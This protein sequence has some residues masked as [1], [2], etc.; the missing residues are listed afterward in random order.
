VVGHYAA[1][2]RS[3]A[4]TILTADDAK[5]PEDRHTRCRP[6]PVVGSSEKSLP[7][8]AS[9]DPTPTAAGQTPSVL[10][11]RSRRTLARPE[12]G[13]L[14]TEGSHV[15]AF[16]AF[17]TAWRCPV[18]DPRSDTIVDASVRHSG[19]HALLGVAWRGEEGLQRGGERAWPR[20][21]AVIKWRT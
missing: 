10:Q 9:D 6:T 20:A 2:S 17:P 21:A 5:C 12:T 4:P 1:P 7:G 3:V 19:F 13:P 18:R 14:D 16:A 8:P 11:P 15:R